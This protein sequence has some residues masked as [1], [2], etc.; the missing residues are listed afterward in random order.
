MSPTDL[1]R[2]LGLLGLFLFLGT[3]VRTP[4]AIPR[5]DADRLLQSPTL[6]LTQARQALTLYEARLAQ[7]EADPVPWLIRLARVCFI[8]GDLAPNGQRQQYYERGR[9]YAE[10]L[11]RERPSGVECHYWLAMHLCG[12]ADVG[13]AFKGRRLLPRILD[14]LQHVLTIDE[15][16][17]QA[18]A[19]RVLGRIYY[20]AP[21]WPLSVGNLEKSL[22]HLSAAVRLAPDTST[23]H[24]Y[25]AET[26]LRMDKTIPARRELEQ[27]LS[28]TRHA[29]CL[30]NLKEDRQKARRLLKEM[31]DSDEW[32]E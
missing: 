13:G 29:I 14:E 16:Y 10:R 15:T 19:H 3:L 12:L 30:S 11:C 22:R 1:P 17:D 26:L 31:T 28:S 27:V 32:Q 24:L 9:G 21:G 23:N 5:V 25:L 4:E 7:A 20:E 8:L 2:V 6:D 18:G